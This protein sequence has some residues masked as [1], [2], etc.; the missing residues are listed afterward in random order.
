M[1]NQKAEIVAQQL[2]ELVQTVVPKV[3]SIA[4]QAYYKI[5]IKDDG[6]GL[7]VSLDVDYKGLTDEMVDKLESDYYRKKLEECDW[8]Y[9]T[10]AKHIGIPEEDMLDKIYAYKLFKFSDKEV[11][12]A[13][14]SA[15]GDVSKAAELL[16]TTT[17]YLRV[18]LVI[19]NLI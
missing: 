10:T 19:R 14:R 3:R 5:E 13:I 18:G 15:N 9:K 16:G 17:E 2:S 6:D 8:N 4:G 11:R 1:N 12:K 7:K